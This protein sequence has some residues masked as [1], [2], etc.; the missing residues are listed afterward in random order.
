MIF[1]GI[2][3][4]AKGAIAAWDGGKRMTVVDMPSQQIQVGR[5]V[6]YRVDARALFDLLPSMANGEPAFVALERVGGMPGQSAASTFTFGFSAALAYA[7]IVIAKMPMTH[8]TPQ[9]WKKRLGV[10]GKKDAGFQGNIARMAGERFPEHAHLWAT[11]TR[12]DRAEAALLALYASI[13]YKEGG[14]VDE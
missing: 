7:A 1:I 9:T 2:D 3:P 6:K 5:A 4:G 8:P 14:A 10:P 12:L 11:A 13:V